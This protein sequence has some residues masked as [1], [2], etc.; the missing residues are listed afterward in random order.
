M[1]LWV[2]IGGGECGGVVG[3]A[4]VVACRR[5]GRER[6]RE[7]NAICFCWGF[8]V[9]NGDFVGCLWWSQL[10]EEVEERESKYK[11]KIFFFLGVYVWFGGGFVGCWL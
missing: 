3:L 11:F 2:T 9:V 5:R 4:V 10:V 6:E 7:R 8:M 1:D